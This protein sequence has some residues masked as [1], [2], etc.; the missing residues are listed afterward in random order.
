[1]EIIKSGSALRLL[2]ENV[3]TYKIVGKNLEISEVL[4]GTDAVFLNNSVLVSVKNLNISEVLQKLV[5]EG[6]EVTSCIPQTD[7]KALFG[8]E[9]V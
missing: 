5:E 9:R 6:V 8:R 2:K 4:K 3:T 7:L 1:G